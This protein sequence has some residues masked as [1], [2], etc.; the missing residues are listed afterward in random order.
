[1]L[2]GLAALASTIFLAGCAGGGSSSAGNADGVTGDTI[3][4]GTTIPLSGSAG[5]VCRPLDQAAKA[6]FDHVN[7]SG[8]ING[9]K[10]EQV[11]LDDQ[12]T[13][14]LALA[15]AKELVRKPV[16][17]IFGGCGTIQPPAVQSIAGPAGVPYLFP[18]ASVPEL[19]G[20]KNAFLALPPFDK[21]MKGITNYAVKTFGAGSIYIIAQ[22]LPGIDKTIA[23]IK[24]A[25]GQLGVNVVGTDITTAGQ[26]DLSSVIL[27]VKN[28]APDYIAMIEG[29]DA[30]RLIDGLN[31][32]QA[33][34]KKK[35][36][37]A[38]PLL[39]AS[40]VKAAKPLP[41]GILL[42]A[43]PV[44]AP[45]SDGLKECADVMSK[46]SADLTQDTNANFTCATAQALTKALQAAGKDLTRESLQK[47][48]LSWKAFDA[49]PALP[50]LTFAEGDKN[51]ADNMFVVSVG[52][53]G[54]KSLST[55]P[56]D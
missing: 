12:Y 22:Q 28:A 3:R 33:L 38:S 15:N 46:V 49:S 24:A 26:A 1:M 37:G 16:F 25:A 2:A 42:G 17:A 31:T 53:D 39:T 4:I 9:R 43:S 30:A 56:I 10:I 36:F 14:P 20:A 51:G 27:K 52:A 6:W 19:A 44:A 13:A 50:P 21:Q 34:P 55:F 5:P 18:A 35:I 41:E 54:I 7:S 45:N 32:Q 8:G 11:V 48:L 23:S 47:T 29:S 40:T